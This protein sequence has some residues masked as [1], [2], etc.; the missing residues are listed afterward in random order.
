MY[1]GRKFVLRSHIL[2]LQRYASSRTAGGGNCCQFESYLS[3]DVICQHHASEYVQNKKASHISQGGKKKR[4][5][6]PQL[7]QELP[8][9]HPAANTFSLIEDCSK[10]LVEKMSNHFL[11][12]TAAAA[13]DRGDG[14]KYHDHYCCF[15]LLGTDLILDSEGKIKLCEVNSH[16]ALGWGTM[17]KVPNVVFKNLIESTLS[18]LLAN[19]GE[20]HDDL[21]N[22][23]KNGDTLD[24]DADNVFQP[25]AS[26]SSISTAHCNKSS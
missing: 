16:P 13:K 22:E 23:K 6:P 19:I 26:V 17:S 18:I 24:A 11:A 14:G 8:T 4:L 15:A 25:L 21:F 10:V 1:Q 7:L 5:P 9:E 20:C 12:S 3:K 2:I